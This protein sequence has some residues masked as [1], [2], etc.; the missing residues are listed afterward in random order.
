MTRLPQSFESCTVDKANISVI[1]DFLLLLKEVGEGC[2]LAPAGL[3]QMRIILA[4]DFETLLRALSS[5]VYWHLAHLCVSGMCML[6]TGGHQ[7]AC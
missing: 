5:C 7:I 6:F 1:V 3:E 4:T 2:E